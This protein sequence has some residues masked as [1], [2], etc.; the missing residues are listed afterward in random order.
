MELVRGDDEKTLRKLT[1]DP[2]FGEWRAFGENLFGIHM[3]KDHILF[4]RPI[5][6]GMCVLELSKTLLYDFYYNHMKPKHSGNCQLL[7]T[8]TDSLIM[9][10]KCE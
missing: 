7:Y 9:H 5:Y 4:N 8:D 10:I 1:S 6:V 2:L 3:H